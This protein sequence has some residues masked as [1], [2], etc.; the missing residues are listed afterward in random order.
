MGKTIFY[1]AMM[2]AVF[3]A[4]TKSNATAS[5]PLNETVSS[6]TATVTG[7]FVN[8]PYGTVSGGASLYLQNGKYKLAL[9]NVSISKGPDLHVYLSKE[10][11]PFNSL[12]WES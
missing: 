3:A 10:L 11:Q 5:A 8:G 9:E 6:D 1:L 7:A 4:C 12:I 2:L